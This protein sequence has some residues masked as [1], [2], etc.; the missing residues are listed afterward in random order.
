M[1]T[2]T[3]E[4]TLDVSETRAVPMSRLVRVELRK[5][6][7][8]RAGMW[9]L[10]AIAA[11]TTL[12]AVIFLLA[13]DESDRTFSNMIGI[14][15][16]PQGFL[17]PVMGILLVTQE[18]GQRTGMVT[19]TL[20]PHRGQVLWAKVI[21]ALVLGV[22][23]L[24]IAL[25]V[26]A[27]GT[28]L[29]GGPDAW[30]GVTAIEPAKFAI[31][32][33]SGVLQGLAFGLLFLNTAGAIVSFFAIPIVF[34]VI[35]GLWSAIRDAQPWIDLG[36]SSV[37]LFEI[38]SLSGEQWAQ[39]GTGTLLWVVLPFAVGMYRVLRTEVK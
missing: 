15:G 24:A 17:L 39:L 13:A 2:T 26:G 33:V 23:A 36:T 25:G 3:Y 20:V 5:M 38:G 30:D 34:S 27:L 4:G 18:W 32:Q 19:F 12:V 14:A 1:S 6:Y 9:L 16:A 37:P 7:D 11:I 8:T 29:F 22:I 10:I 31:A 35:T 21:A 28:A